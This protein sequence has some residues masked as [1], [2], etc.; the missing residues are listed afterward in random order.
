MPRFFLG[1]VEKGAADG[2]TVL[3]SAPFKL[4][5][6]TGTTN[7]RLQVT[8]LAEKENKEEYEEDRRGHEEK[9]PR[10]YNCQPTG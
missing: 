9:L 3:S 6:R 8:R 10:M 4:D 2:R 1:R 7:W 5:P